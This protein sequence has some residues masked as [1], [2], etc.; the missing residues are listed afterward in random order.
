MVSLIQADDRVADVEAMLAEMMATPSIPDRGTRRLRD[1]VSR[2]GRIDRRLAARI[3]HANRCLMCRDDDWIEFYL[4]TLTGFFLVPAGSRFLLP[5]ERENILLRWLEE[6]DPFSNVGERR[7]MLR[8]FLKASHLSDRFERCLL[9]AVKENLLHHSARWL[10]GRYREAGV[11]DALDMHLVRRLV[12]GSDG[13]YPAA[14]SRARLDFLT[15]L[16]RE[17]RA[18]NDP[19][20]W[21]SF[22]QQKTGD[23]RPGSSQEVDSPDR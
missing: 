13:Q 16:D 22:V 5:E 10:D 19:S 4:E 21:R 15:A 9:D 17:A 6:G 18:F 8:L 11:I 12:C 3:F 2:I 20:S 1:A 23:R 7:L 14:L